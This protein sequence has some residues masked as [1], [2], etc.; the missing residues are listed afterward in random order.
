[1]GWLVAIALFVAPWAAQAGVVPPAPMLQ[2]KAWALL[3]ARSGQVLAA[4]E[5]TRPYPPASLT[6]MMALYL[7]FEVIR[8]G[9]LRL[10][11]RVDVSEKAWKAPGSKMFLDPRMHPTVEELLHGIATQSGNDATIALAE[12]IAGSEAAFVQMMNA[13]AKELGLTHTHFANATGLPA[14]GHYSSA[15]D[16]A[17]LG[18]ALWRDFPE[19]YKLFSE[20]EYTYAG[21]RQPNRN[22]LLW[23]DPRVDGIKTGHTEEAGFCLVASA[24][25]HGMRLVAAVLGAKSD[26]GRAREARKLLRYGFRNFATVRPAEREL[27]RVVPVYEGK[28]D[29]VALVPAESVWLT[30][31]KGDARRIVYRL[32]Y[33]KPLVAPIKKGERLGEL[34]AVLREGQSERTIKTIPMVA[35]SAVPRAGWLGRQWDRIRLWLAGE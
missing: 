34:R 25:D 13:K 30:V 29:E 23:M 10:D 28:A 26:L 7:A 17:R 18:A 3:D 6:K 9:R 2:A 11:E 4:H 35:A 27:R 22:R 33:K 14:E 31:P 1:M 15:L 12:W 8:D 21:I 19:F 16:L 20:R 24:E 32:R 5:E